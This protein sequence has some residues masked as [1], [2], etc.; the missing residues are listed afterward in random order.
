MK[1][2]IR[3]FRTSHVAQIIQR[4]V[5]KDSPTQYIVHEKTT[6]LKGRR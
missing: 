3:T 6:N 5:I 4:Y 1:Y 2:S